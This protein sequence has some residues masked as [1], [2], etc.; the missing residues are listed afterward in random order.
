[1]TNEI[2]IVV[3]AKNESA[4][5][6]K[7]VE[8]SAKKTES[9][10]S[11]LGDTTDRAATSS[12]TASGAF[13]ALS[14]GVALAGLQS[15]KHIETLSNENAKLDAQKTRIDLQIA[16]LEQSAT[17]KGADKKAIEAQIKALQG[18][19]DALDTQKDKND[20]A[21]QGIEEHQ[22]KMQNLTYALMAGQLAFDAISGVADLATLAM[23][24]NKVATV[25]TAVAQ[26]AA[27]AASKAWAA[28]QWLLNAALTA[29]P[30]GLVIIAIVALV[31]VLVLAYKRSATFRSVV[32]AAFRVVQAA[33][34]VMWSGI[35]A[36]FG[37]LMSVFSA[38]QSRARAVAG[39]IRS[40]LGSL[41]S[42]ARGM[43]GRV[44]GAFGSMFNPLR[45]AARTAI[46]TV[47][48]W[49]QGLLNFAR[50]IP[51]QI[52][53]AIRGVVPGFAHGGIVGQAATGATSSGLTMTGEHGPELL[54]LPPGTR[55][56]SNPDTRRALAGSGQGGGGTA[57]TVRLDGSG[58][59]K[60]LRAEIRA[61]GGN[62]QTV[63][64]S[65]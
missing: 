34:R 12:G 33:A 7:S 1:M 25:A 16:A 35:R 30:I 36:Y 32:Q 43:P 41:V 47:R 10:V 55:V 24:A 18:Q 31:A 57:I 21:A 48:S 56:R 39:G 22:Q 50:N 17:V 51:G 52:G 46:N 6:F 60:N 15:Q 58:L 65:N 42:F 9:A 19:S 27:A 64:G 45:N 59:L 40:V 4:P 28:A 54:H 20:L 61:K 37:A 14:S 49:L 29:N 26:K 38:L 53:G 5:G 2:S 8:D 63:L 23:N 44:R 13:G 3:K 11:R 62:V